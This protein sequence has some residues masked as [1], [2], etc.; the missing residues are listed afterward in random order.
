MRLDGLKGS[1]DG[2]KSVPEA[3][4]DECLAC[5]VSEFD[6]PLALDLQRCSR[7]PIAP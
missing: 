7:Q 1:R 6:S 3:K 2:M 5:F 4:P